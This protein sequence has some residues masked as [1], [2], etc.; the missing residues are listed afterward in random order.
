MNDEL[1]TRVSSPLGGVV[2]RTVV[3]HDALEIAFARPVFSE[4]RDHRA[5]GRAR[6][7]RRDDGDDLHSDESKSEF[8]TPTAISRRAWARLAQ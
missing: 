8:A 1:C 7:V 6:L 4:R 3:D 2:A 5:D